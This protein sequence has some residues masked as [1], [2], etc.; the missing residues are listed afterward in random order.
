MSTPDPARAAKIP[1][2]DPATQQHECILEPDADRCK[3]APIESDAKPAA[4]D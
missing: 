3:G 1:W 4:T 2:K